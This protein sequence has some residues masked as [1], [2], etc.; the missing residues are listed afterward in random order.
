MQMIEKDGILIAHSNAAYV[1]ELRLFLEANGH[2]VYS[3]ID[4]AFVALG[5]ILKYQPG[6][7]LLEH[8]FHYLSARDVIAAIGRKEISTKVIQIFPENFGGSL[9][10][11]NYIH[12]DDPFEKITSCINSL[13]NTFQ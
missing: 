1:H 13:I 5:F 6:L 9:P 12:I 3:G 11:S 2:S 10:N 8:E 4:D 7:A